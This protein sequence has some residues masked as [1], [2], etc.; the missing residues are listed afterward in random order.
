[1]DKHTGPRYTSVCRGLIFTLALIFAPAMQANA[2]SCSSA[3]TVANDVWEEFRNAAE[4]VGCRSPLGGIAEYAT[5]AVTRFT[6]ETIEDVFGWWNTVAGNRWATIG[7]RTLG[8]ETELGTVINTTRR[9]FVSLV[10]QFSNGSIRVDRRSGSGKV[11]I[12]ATD[13]NGRTTRLLNERIVPS[14]GLNFSVNGAN[15]QGKVLSVILQARTASFAYSIRKTETPIEWNFGKIK[16]L[17]DLHVHQAA[18]LGFGGHWLHGSHTGP[19][20][21]ALQSCRAV[22]VGDALTASAQALAL[23]TGVGSLPLPE[24]NKLHAIP[25]NRSNHAAETVIRHGDGADG[26]FTDWPHHSDIAHQQVHEDYLKEAHD[27]GLKLLVVSAVNNELLCRGLHLGLY[28]GQNKWACDDMSNIKR[29]IEAFNDFDRKHD[30]YEIALH[31]WHARKIINEGKLAVVISAESSHILPRSEGD[32][33]A[34]LDE[35]YRMGLRSMQIVHERDNRFAGAAPHRS[36]FLPHQVTSNPLTTVKA[37]LEADRLDQHYMA[38]FDLDKDGKNRKGLLSDGQRLVDAMV[39][40][41]MLIDAAHYSDNAFIDLY[42]RM[43]SHHDSMP[44]YVSHSRFRA[45]LTDID[46]SHQHEFLTT[47]AQAEMLSELGGMVGLRTGVNHILSR[48]KDATTAKGAYSGVAN[49]CAGSSRSYAQLVAHGELMKL[50]IAFGSDFGGVTQQLGP[51]F[52]NEACYAAK[53]IGYGLDEPQGKAPGREFDTVGLKHIGYLP[54]LYKDLELLN[55]RGVA[56][57]NESAENFIAM[58]EKVYGAEI[59]AP[60]VNVGCDNDND[61][62]IGQWCDAGIDLSPNQC[63]DLVADGGN[64]PLVGGGHA[65]E[66]GT[67]RFGRCYTANTVAMGDSC[68]VD[69]QCIAGKCGNTVP[70]TDSVCVCDADNQCS[71][72]EYCDAGL[73]L[74]QNSC[75]AKK[76][77]NATCDVFNGGRTCQ[78][79]TCS[80]GRCYTANAVA[81]GGTCYVNA[82]CA[83]GK[84]SSQ[85]GFRGQCVCDDDGDCGNNQWCDRGLDFTLNSCKAKLPNGAV[86]GVIGEINV[87]HR[88]LSGKCKASFGTNLK[89]KS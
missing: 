22:N 49:N 66:S 77:D 69:A 27:K 85:N 34:Q 53:Q 86:C 21:E 42:E 51:R 75:V 9:T 29:Q 59:A 16:G 65:C 83:T 46:I 87:G 18:E 4:T 44:F 8:T 58:W 79:G 25:I 45:R 55:T 17:A 6:A 43:K 30:W 37:L 11:T 7:P 81:T 36:N 13:Q 32:F 48:P 56:K 78:S 50:D 60:S 73:D 26:G 24:K 57:L 74:H 76:P 41:R 40:R 14:T 2:A 1:M 33:V 47:N 28:Q 63:R 72:S 89:C 68:F 80:Y 52:G 82:A 20:N 10:P 71:S 88:C 5:C 12:C 19:R 61:C 62:D 54:D 39:Q 35:L 15:A 64:C 70:G 23:L 38:A 3:A 67:C 84:C 31:P